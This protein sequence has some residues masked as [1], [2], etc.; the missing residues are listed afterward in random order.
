MI[1]IKNHQG[2][3]LKRVDA[4]GSLPPIERGSLSKVKDLSGLN[5]CHAILYVLRL[6]GGPLA[7]E[8]IWAGLYDRGKRRG[9][10]NKKR[11]ITQRSVLR[12]LRERSQGNWAPIAIFRREAPG[13]WGLTARGLRW[14][15]DDQQ[16]HRSLITPK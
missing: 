15:K 4:M 16:P 14:R 8:D 13:I 11:E 1:E 3:V 10:Y 6:A 7:V 9:L 12:C 5:C 2:K